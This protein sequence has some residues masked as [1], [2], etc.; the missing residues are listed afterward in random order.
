[1]KQFSGYKDLEIQE[2]SA[3][4]TSV[5]AGVYLARIIAVRDIEEKEYLEVKFDIVK[6]DYTD[7]FKKASGG[8]INSWYNQGIYRVSYKETAHQLF[9]NFITAIQ[10]SNQNYVWDWN[11]HSLVGK[12]FVVVMGEEE[13]EWEGEIRVSVKPRQARSIEA[14][15]KGEVKPLPI[16][17]LKKPQASATPTIPEIDPASLPF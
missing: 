16:K 15:Q 7:F 4:I 5:P 13:Y 6:G 9:K 3:S 1:M 2:V 14:Y 11:E 17:K 12:F 10:K 8:D